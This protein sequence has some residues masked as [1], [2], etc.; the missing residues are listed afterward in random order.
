MPYETDKRMSSLQDVVD[1]V[2][3]PSPGPGRSAYVKTKTLVYTVAFPK[4]VLAEDSFEE[5]TRKSL[6]TLDDRLEQA[7]TDKN[8]V[9]EATVFLKDISSKCEFDKAWQEWAPSHGISRAAIGGVDLGPF[10]V[11]MKITAAMPDVELFHGPSPGPGRTAW[12]KTEERVYTVAFPKGVKPG[13]SVEEQTRKSFKE[14]DERLAQAGTDKGRITEATVYL[15]DFRSKGEFDKVW[16]EYIPE[17]CGVSRAAI[18]GVDLGQFAVEMKITAALPDVPLVRGPSPGKG[19]SVYVSSGHLVNT[20]AFPKGVQPNDGVKEQTR[21]SLKELDERLALAGTD[22]S[23][24]V[25]ATVYLKDMS[26]KSEF[27]KVWQEWVPENC[28]VSRACIGKADMGPFAVEMKI[29][30][31]LPIPIKKR[32]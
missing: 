32:E 8:S 23:R 25:E 29:T 5:Q 26:T 17:E 13:D 19:R 15:N 1:I 24:L 27:D 20:V 7:G 4:G 9:L 28:G 18:G 6:K 30:A 3:G 11:E 2:R 22:K 21:K 31:A 14:L 10:E 16:Q 12:V